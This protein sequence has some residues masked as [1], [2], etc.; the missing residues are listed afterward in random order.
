MCRDPRRVAACHVHDEYSQTSAKLT[1]KPLT[2]PA[3]MTRTA[4]LVFLRRRVLSQLC[5]LHRILL[6]H[7]NP[8]GPGSAKYVIV[9]WLIP[10]VE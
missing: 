10:R 2:V 1:D 5:A 4:A 6:G 7:P 3:C 9:I 8:R